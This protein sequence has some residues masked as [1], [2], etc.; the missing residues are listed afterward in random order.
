MSDMHFK[1]PSKD[2]IKSKM[3]SALCLALIILSLYT[4]CYLLFFRTTGVDITKDIEILYRGEDGSGVVSVRNKNL[5]Y[6]QRIQEFMDTVE[7]KVTPNKNLKNGDK[8]KISTTYDETLA[9]RYHINAIN[10]VKEVTVE[11]LP[12]RY[13]NV[14]QIPQTLLDEVKDNSKK[15]L[16]KN[17]SSILSDDFTAF[18]FTS[19]PELENYRFMYRIFLNAKDDESKDKILDIYSI[20]AKGEVNVSNKEEKLETKDETIYYMITYNE[21]NTSGKILKEDSYGEKIIVSGKQNLQKEKDFKNYMSH[22][23]GK[24]YTIEK[25]E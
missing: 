23:Y 7:Y 22:K 13:E 3:I 24:Q 16:E 6:N 25:I 11:G 10:V 9:S 19:E 1:V 14:K 21:I 4:T 18:Y 17:M 5:N 2:A 12:V 20:T 15:Y 8:I